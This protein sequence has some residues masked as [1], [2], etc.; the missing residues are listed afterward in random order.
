MKNK[1]MMLFIIFLT[2][3]G[4]LTIDIYLPALPNMVH[5]LNTTKQLVQL[6]LTMFL[7]G[8]AF[9]QLFYG[10]ISDRYGRKPILYFGLSLFAL[11]NLSCMFAPDITYLICSRIG[12]GLGAGA[13]ST[14]SRAISRDMFDGKTLSKISAYAAMSWALVPIIA[15]LIGSYVEH[16]LGWRYIFGLLG[17]LGLFII[18]I[19]HKTIPETYPDH[20]SHKQSALRNYKLLLTHPV[21]LTYV[22]CVLII[23]GL[24]INFNLVAPFFIQEL[25]NQ[26]IIFYG[27]LICFIA[28]GYFVGS[29]ASSYL[30]NY[31]GAHFII[32]IGC[33]G[34]LTVASCFLILSLIEVENLYLFTIT[35]FFILTFSSLIYPQFIAKCLS[36]FVEIAGSAGSLFGFI[37]FLGGTVYSFITS[38]LPHNKLEPYA[39]SI[40]IQIVFLT[41]IN[42]AM[43]S[44][45]KDL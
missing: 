18:I 8:Y 17:L 36:P 20:L 29:I 23:Y 25:F 1:I 41:A 21:F 14:M 35:M 9:S 26:S 37:V 10:P 5:D 39:I 19:M 11:S 30:I 12:Q 28:L 42:L 43:N 22:L 7:V 2:V 32:I 6:S 34:L 31:I 13:A 38:Q 27:W 40:F 3:V 15:P 45:F 4:Q 33:L 16:Y 44:R 24:F